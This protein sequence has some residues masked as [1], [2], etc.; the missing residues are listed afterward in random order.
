M[1]S[2]GVISP[3][4]RVDSTARL[5]ALRRHRWPLLLVGGWILQVCVRLLFAEHRTAP[6]LIPDETGYLLGA[7]LLAGGAP[8]D[9]SG[10]SFYQPGYPLL[11]SPAYWLSDD[12]VTVYHLVV[13]INS[14]IGAALLPLA[15]VALRRLNLPRPQA[16]LLATVT[17][18]LPSVLY[19]S[20]F[21]MADAVL[22]VV[23][24]GWLLLIHSSIAGG[25]PGHGAAAS[26]V[27][28]YCYCVH[29]RGTIIVL[30]HAGLLV[31]ALW[32]RWASKRDTAVIAGMLVTASAAAWALNGWARSQI[33]P[34][35]VNPLGDFLSRRLTGVDGL[36]WTLGLATGKIWYLI[37]STV[38]VAGV[39]LV[40]V[41]VL[42]ARRS[43]PIPIRA[44]ASVMLAAIA[45]IAI[46][47]S[48][49]VPDE[50]AVAN[51][52][53]GRYLGC[54]TPVLF[55]AGAVFAVRA[56]RRAAVQVVLATAALALVTGGIVCLHAGDRLSRTFFTALEFPEICFFTWSWDSL[57]LWSATC[58]ALL[59]LALSGALIAKWRRGGLLIVAAA[60]I[61]FA[62]AD[63]TVVANRVVRHLEKGLWSDT[64]LAPAGLRAQDRVAVNYPGL[65]W[66]IW[67]A[68]ASQVRTRLVPIDR[69]RR[70]TLP[71]DATLVVVPW[72]GVLPPEFSWPAV[73]AGWHIVLVRHTFT[74]DWVAWRRG[75]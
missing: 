14:L 74:G 25:R 33:Y 8:G 21:A 68:Q 58:V 48:A 18:L 53:Y 39:G 41:G 7:R 12:P 43:T 65:P 24:L 10:W 15:Y 32:R 69:S 64:S 55:M 73:P 11:I 31:V 28:A 29:S 4:E 71:P 62:L 63:T 37:V 50:G 75:R 27:A 13:A 9:L 59:L 45:G 47:S 34:G 22:P 5:S 3:A 19:Y 40:A 16:Y 6:I 2:P 20:Q 61:A 35:G 67:V 51:F 72:D 1:G 52:A 46:A 70:E 56:T 36:G 30:V 57:K 44:T 54:L 49:A 38:G 66:R 17:A 23:M 26:A 60:F 42:A